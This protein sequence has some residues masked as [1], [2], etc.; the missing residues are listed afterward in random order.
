MNYNKELL[1]KNIRGDFGKGIVIGTVSVFYA[2][3]RLFNV[4]NNPML[5]LDIFMLGLFIY[6]IYLVLFKYVK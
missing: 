3:F 4:L 1:I 2:F 5:F 6:S